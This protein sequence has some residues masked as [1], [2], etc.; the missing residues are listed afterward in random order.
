MRG[1]LSLQHTALRAV[2]RIQIYSP[3]A[4]R[5]LIRFAGTRKQQTPRS[6]RKQ[7]KK[8]S[9]PRGYFIDLRAL[10]DALL[11][12]S[13]SLERLTERLDTPTKKY[14]SEDHGHKLTG[15]Y[16]EYACDDV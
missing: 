1:G 2:P 10:A 13:W 11:G 3:D 4:R 12:G 14:K 6:L 9:T 7:E 8:V 15:T 16:L 5:P